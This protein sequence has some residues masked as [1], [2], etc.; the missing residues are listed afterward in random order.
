MLFRSQVL[1]HGRWHTIGV[2]CHSHAEAAS[3]CAGL[4]PPNCLDARCMDW[5]L[6]HGHRK[7]ALARHKLQ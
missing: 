5:V 6:S 3:Q 7:Q 2:D 4:C 1:S